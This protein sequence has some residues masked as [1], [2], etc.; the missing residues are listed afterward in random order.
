MP[1]KVGGELRLAGLLIDTAA[2]TIDRNDVG[3]GSGH[4]H[5]KLLPREFCGCRFNHRSRGP[6]SGTSWTSDKVKNLSLYEATHS[7]PLRKSLRT[8]TMFGT[9]S[10]KVS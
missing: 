2:G 3:E 9:L 1:D 6:L 10:E 8:G 4:A 7:S 5:G